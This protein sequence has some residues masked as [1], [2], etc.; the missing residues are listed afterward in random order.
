[1]PDL[2]VGDQTV[3]GSGVLY[4]SSKT[5]AVAAVDAPPTTLTVGGPG[6]GIGARVNG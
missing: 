6:E 3:S 2:V 4:T 5:V 1:M